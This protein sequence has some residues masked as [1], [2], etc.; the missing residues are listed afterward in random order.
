M[1]THALVRLVTLYATGLMSHGLR[2]AEGLL[3][4]IASACWREDVRELGDL[5]A[6]IGATT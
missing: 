3:R 5:H 1:A 2:K 4:R 6:V